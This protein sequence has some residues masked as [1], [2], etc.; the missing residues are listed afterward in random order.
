[1]FDLLCCRIK[2]QYAH[3]MDAARH[4]LSC[5]INVTRKGGCFFEE[6]SRQV[7]NYL[8]CLMC[9]FA[10]RINTGCLLHQTLNSNTCSNISNTQNSNTCSNISNTCIKLLA[11][12]N[13]QY[14]AV[15][16]T[17]CL[18]THLL[19][20]VKLYSRIHVKDHGDCTT[21]HSMTIKLF[22]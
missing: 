8:T 18:Y 10:T 11:P 12:P 15:E 16:V 1:V 21:K 3:C 4:N 14:I 7:P 6:G 9:N 5:R 20:T 17:R 2:S 22:V 19:R 13:L